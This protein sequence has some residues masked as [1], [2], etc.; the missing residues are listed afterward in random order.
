MSEDS[1]RGPGRP[2]DADMEDRVYTAVLEVYWET[3]W[4]GFTFDA[5]SR[6]AKVG[7]A[8]LY[9]RWADKEELLVQALEARSPLSTPIDTGSV[10]GDLVELAEQLA[11]GYGELSGLVSLRVTLDAR[12]NPDLL[13][14]LTDT[15]NQSRLVTARRIVRR[16]VARGELPEGTSTTLLLELVTGAVL[17]RALFSQAHS[18]SRTTAAVDHST[19][20]VD[21]V[22]RALS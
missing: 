11:V 18:G 15:L 6:R 17:A 16:A 9:R 7:R 21:T 1:P 14:H 13:S 10:R 19:V 3:S 22:L 20:V 5:V 12:V 2:R 4:R 8:A